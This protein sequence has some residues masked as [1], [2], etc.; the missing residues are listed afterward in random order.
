MPDEIDT[1]FLKGFKKTIVP[2]LKDHKIALIVGGG[3]TAR[4]YMAAARSVNPD[5][6]R[7]ALDLIGIKSTHLNEQLIFA[8]FEKMADSH[9]FIQRPKKVSTKKRLILAAGWEQGASTDFNAVQLAK[10]LNAKRV[11]NLTNVDYVYTK[12]P[13]KFS[14]ARPLPRISWTEFKKIIGGKWIPGA[15]VPFDR[16]KICSE[17]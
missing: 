15:N 16:F 2:L 1:K 12:N 3:R 5:L 10:I 6:S 7:S 4:K 9:L 14:S 8:M 13:K 11:L 17:A